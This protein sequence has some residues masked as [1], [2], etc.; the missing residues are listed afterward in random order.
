MFTFANH[1]L[2]PKL[3]MIL[4]S[5]YG[6]ILEGIIVFVY[7]AIDTIYSIYIMRG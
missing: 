5:V 6:Y 2:L 3:F 7:Q 1:E 4:S